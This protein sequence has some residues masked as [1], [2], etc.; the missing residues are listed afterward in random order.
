MESTKLTGNLVSLENGY[1]L[2][3]SDPLFWKKLLIRRP[4]D[5][6]AMYHVGLNL[7]RE[8]RNYLDMYK[9]K[10]MDKYLTSYQR[11]MKESYDL[12]NGSFRKGFLTARQDVLR[13]E[14]AM[15]VADRKDLLSNK[16][17][18]VSDSDLTQLV[19]A[20]I[21]GII[22][23]IVLLIILA[24][25]IYPIKTH[26]TTNNN[27]NNHYAYMLPYEVIEKKPINLTSTTVSNDNK[28]IEVKREISKE[29]LV[30]QLVAELKNDY[31]KDPTTS[32]QIVA[33]DETKTER[34]MAFWAGGD[35]NVQVYIYP[36][37]STKF[38]DDKER[39]LWETTTVLRSAAYRFLEKNGYLT[40]DLDTLT[41]PFPNNYLT[42]LPSDPY[43]LKN[44]VNLSAP[45]V[46]GWLYLIEENPSSIKSVSIVK[47]AVTPNI[48]YDKEI[49]FCPISISINKGDH[50]LSV[51]S[52]TQTIRRYSVA[53]GKGDSTP[54]GNYIIS[55]KLMNPDK[56]V[57]RDKNVY[58]TRAMELSN[59]KF[60]IHGTNSPSSIGQEVSEGCIRLNNLEMEELYAM[61]P[62]Y[63]EVTI[64]KPA[65]SD[66]SLDPV[67]ANTYLYN[68][69]D[70]SKEEDNSRVYHWAH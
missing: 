41:Q 16:K 30:N 58:G 47:E 45:G 23:A 40:N 27:V 37:Q 39:Q 36:L 8:A 55:K 56:F 54:D 70:N 61:I 38:I 17:P 33:V 68:R 2:S 50:T 44:T 28:I 14:Q 25:I 6:E 31:L 34:G 21:L 60:A 4:E 62:M 53:L 57:P 3:K 24:I 48:P 13:M 65:F 1:Y 10:K 51:I 9:N 69:G 18:N 67:E 5:M 32:K 11:L 52:G 42:E 64:A 35:K 22:L 26:N 59:T 49:P 29:L 12:V 20:L 15:K 43:H 19:T 46:G 66:G 63:T 7:E